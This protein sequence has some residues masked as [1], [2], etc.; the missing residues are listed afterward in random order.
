MKKFLYELCCILTLYSFQSVDNEGNNNYSKNKLIVKE[1]L[2]NLKDY[3]KKNP[4]YWVELE[5]SQFDESN[6]MIQKSLGFYKHFNEFEHSFQLGIETISNN[7][8]RILIDSSSKKIIVQPKVNQFS[9]E[10]SFDQIIE[11]CEYA[12]VVDSGK[13]TKINLQF[14]NENNILEI[15]AIDIQSNRLRKISIIKQDLKHF[16]SVK[17]E[18]AFFNYKNN[19]KIKKSETSFDSILKNTESNNNK[20]MLQN[21]YASYKI[22]GTFNQ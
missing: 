20:M 12:S 18:I 19:K 8:G 14:N 10:N 13:L 7:K 17:F 9:W 2:I 11:K 15:F 5:Y 3:Y 1:I 4:N 16:K 6:N 21:N 22:I